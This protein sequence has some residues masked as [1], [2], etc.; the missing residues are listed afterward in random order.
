MKSRSRIAW[1]HVVPVSFS[2]TRPRSEKPELQYDHVAPRG[3]FWA[4]SASTS[5]YFSRQSSPRPVSVK[6]SPSM[7]LVWVSRCRM[8]TLLVTSGSASR[9]SGTTST[10]GVSSSTRPS[11]TSWRTTVAVQTFVTEPIWNSDVVVAGDP[12]ARLS[13][14]YAASTSSSSRPGE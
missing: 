2:I 7:P 8:V 11:S 5:T 10:T 1:S 3:W 13:V 4:A 6:T 9:S 14:P 12:V